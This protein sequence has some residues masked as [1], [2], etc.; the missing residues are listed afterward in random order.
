MA[1]N[2]IMKDSRTTSTQRADRP[3]TPHRGR[4]APHQRPLGTAICNLTQWDIRK[5]VDH[6]NNAPRENLGG[7]T[8]YEKAL[9]LYGKEFL[10]KLQLRY[11][12]PDEVTLTPKLL[13][14]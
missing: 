11:V 9:W 3:L 8:P 7:K 12:A 5:A 14:K 1:D 4:L 6:I 2:T 13:T 10:K